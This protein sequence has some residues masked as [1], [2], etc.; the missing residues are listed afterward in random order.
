MHPF[1]KQSTAESK[2]AAM[3]RRSSGDLDGAGD[4][5]GD[6]EGCATK[7]VV[8]TECWTEQTDS[9]RLVRKCEKTEQLLRQCAG[10]FFFLSSVSLVY[11]DIIICFVVVDNC[12][13]YIDCCFF[14]GR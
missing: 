14:D 13:D 4:G 1:P 5:D 12:C 2:T 11:C 3:W 7:R 8:K 6:G 9:G 10:R